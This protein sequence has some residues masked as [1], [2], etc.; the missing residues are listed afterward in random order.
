ML[1]WHYDNPLSLVAGEPSKANQALHD[2]ALLGPGR[3]LAQLIDRYQSAG[4]ARTLPTKR[5]ATLA[6]WSSAYSWQERVTT[7][8]EQQRHKEREAAE[9]TRS[10]RQVVLQDRCWAVAER[11]AGRV[12]S[13]LEFPLAT[14]ERVE[15][16]SKAADGKTT[17]IEQTIVKPTRWTFRDA[18][19]IAEIT[20][21]L[22]R[23]ALDL[24]GRVAA[25]S[26]LAAL[27]E[28]D[29]E[30]MSLEE[31]LRLRSQIGVPTATEQ[32][33]S[34]RKKDRVVMR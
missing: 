18:A 11:L 34:V 5:I 3:S 9:A 7:Y 19:Q 29:L 28:V 17:I 16:V 6:A 30:T 8:D 14:V 20:A 25:E 22:G 32:K 2:Y 12:E 33:E 21:K 31:L 4:E 27:N 10:A 13:M 23:L 1:Q 24:Q 26:T 15:K